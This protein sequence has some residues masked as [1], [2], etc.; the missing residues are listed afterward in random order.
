MGLQLQNAQPYLQSHPHLI[1][2]PLIFV[3]VTVFAFMTLGDAVRD[4]ID[5][6]GRK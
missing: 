6:K 3:G 1:L 5:P 2:F 4:A